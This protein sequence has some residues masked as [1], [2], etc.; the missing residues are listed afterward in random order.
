MVV[1]DDADRL[2]P[3]ECRRAVFSRQVLWFTFHSVFLP[4][5][6]VWGWQYWGRLT[7]QGDRRSCDPSS[8][9]RLVGIIERH[10]EICTHRADE[11]GVVSDPTSP[12]IRIA[13]PSDGPRSRGCGGLW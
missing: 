4:S 1:F 13:S 2:V 12:D 11:E 7:I 10:G 8:R 9:I 6:G 5:R 3:H